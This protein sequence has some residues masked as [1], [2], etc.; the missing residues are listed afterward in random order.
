MMRHKH[1]RLEPV[2]GLVQRV[3]IRVVPRILRPCLGRGVFIFPTVH[4][5]TKFEEGLQCQTLY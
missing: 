2:D 3:Q 4:H 5:K 1:V